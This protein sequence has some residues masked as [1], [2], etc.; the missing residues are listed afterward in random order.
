MKRLV[1]PR[2]VLFAATL[3]A[4]LWLMTPAS[5]GLLL[6]Q[7][8]APGRLPPT[9]TY[10][11]TGD[12]HYLGLSLAID[13]P[14]TIDAA[15][16]MFKDLGIRRVYWRGL[17]AKTWLIDSRER[18]ENLRYYSFWKWLRKL[19]KEVDPDK[20][21]I[22]AARKHGIEIWGVATLVDWG[23]P[24]D[25]PGFNDWP[26][27]NESRLRLEHPEWAPVD[28]HG[29]LKQGGTIELA[30][31]EARK[32]LVDLHMQVMNTDRYDGM[33]FLTYAENHSMRFQDEFG[34]S[35]PIVKEFKR[36]HG[37]D[38]RF[39][40]FTRNG[41][42]EDWVRLRGEYLTAYLQELKQAL[43]K[44]QQKL[45][46]F[47]NPWQPHALQPWNVPET[48][49]TGGSMYLDLE[50][51]IRAGTLDQ[52]I[53]YGYCYRPTQLKT[54]QDL[55]WMTRQTDTKVTVLTSSPT[56]PSWKPLTDQGVEVSS[57]LLEDEMYLDR[58]AIPEQPLSSLTSDRAVLRMRTL[59]QVVQGQT[60]ATVADVAP[61]AKDP[62]VIVRRLAIQ[63]LGKL[64]DP[65]A[66]PVIEAALQDPEPAV[67]YY[68]GAALRHVNGPDSAR[69][70]LA[71]VDAW[72]HHPLVEIAVQT[73]SRLKPAPRDE[74]ARVMLEHPNEIVRMTAARSLV[75]LANDSLLDTF[76]KGLNDSNQYVRF[77]CTEAL[78]Q[79]GSNPAAVQTLIEQL[80]REGDVV[81]NNRAATSLGAIIAR[82]DDAV[83]SLGP[84]VLEG[85][86]KAYAR[87][88]DGN[89]RADAEWA[90]RPVGNALLKFGPEGEAVLRA[91]M[92]Q[93]SDKR[94][95]EQAW[96]SLY[97]RKETSQFS[98]VTEKENQ[99]AFRRRPAILR[100]REV[101][102]MSQDF[103]KGFSLALV[104]MA[105]DVN[106]PGGRWGAFADGG[107]AIDASVAS[108][109]KQSIKF[110]RGKPSLTAAVAK[111]VSAGAPY[112]AS[113]R[114]RRD[115]DRSA[116]S[117]SV[118]GGTGTRA[119]QAGIFIAPD[120]ELR[121]RDAAGAKWVSTS[122]SI[123]PG[124]WMQVR[125]LVDPS[126]GACRVSVVADDGT[127]RASEAS[128]PVSAMENVRYITFS[129]QGEPGNVTYVDDVEL[130]EMM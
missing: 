96:K 114:V 23:S 26:F 52:L 97:I 2:R 84:Q 4:A 101:P 15:F 67:R 116:I 79:L 121:L 29:V 94:L 91:F 95:A 17:E 68:A 38:L 66:I 113:F 25:T 9:D 50:T 98:M 37:V 16:A 28:R 74:L 77:A 108:S 102:R 57:A 21:A 7:S 24:A 104:G 59:A 44:N 86:K 10:I 83:R 125:L 90:Y 63:A 93:T 8:P 85:L 107:P 72:S 99:E 117:V 110:V 40:E 118:A 80:K 122:L 109:G 61:L 43:A 127:E 111:G 31:P 78:G 45:G 51:L 18:P 41:T 58:S 81:V 112:R 42:R 48:I 105:G 14:A 47:I 32:A 119:D 123:P 13:T 73:L 27:N 55:M 49:Q 12:N 88:G 126:A 82:N 75:F 100:S 92:E 35:E 129:P 120:G 39:D 6:A 22:E 115:S 54:V 62:N 106:V 69:K 64:A 65:S 30:Y 20:L 128:V 3:M 70:L 76:I 53:V 87:L 19:Y 5:V 34:Y 89:G 60:K 103:E 124:K 33:V 1:S 36:R 46:I 56:D 11:S 71:A 130:V